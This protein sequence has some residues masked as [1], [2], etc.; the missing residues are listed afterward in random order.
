MDEEEGFDNRSEEE[1]NERKLLRRET[2]IEYQGTCPD[3]EICYNLE[4]SPKGRRQN[5]IALGIF[6]NSCQIAWKKCREQSRTCRGVHQ[7][8][9]QA[10]PPLILEL[11]EGVTLIIL[12]DFVGRETCC[13]RAQL[14]YSLGL[15]QPSSMEVQNEETNA[16]LRVLC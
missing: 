11:P 2:Q 5:L 1:N 12:A 14:Y 13:L 15:K 4:L 10:L 16:L 6:N 3:S 8:I 7:V 9:Y